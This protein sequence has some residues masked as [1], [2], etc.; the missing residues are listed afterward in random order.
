M[1]WVD[2]AKREAA[3]YYIKTCPKCGGK[4]VPCGDRTCGFE[5]YWVRCTDCNN[6]SGQHVEIRYAIREWNEASK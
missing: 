6:K 3:K 5:T 2:D 1:S 4:G